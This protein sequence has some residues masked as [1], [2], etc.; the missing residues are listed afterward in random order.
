MSECRLC[1]RECGVDR[2]KEV[3]FCGVSDRVRI[4]RAAP[5]YFEE[6]CISGTRGSGAIFFAG[7]SLSCVFCQNFDV[8][9]RAKGR[10]VSVSRLAEIIDSLQGCHNINFVTG[11][12]Y[13][14]QIISALSQSKNKLPVVWNSS[15]YEKAET[16]E[17]LNG[18]ANIYLPDFK[19]RDEN[20]AK[21]FS[22]APDYFERAKNA[23][24]EMVSQRGK[25]VFDDNGMLQSGVL[26][27][28]LVLPSHTDDSKRVLSYLHA[29]YGDDIYISIMRQY[30]P[31]RDT[32]YKELSRRLTSYE[33]DKVVD[34]ALSIGVKNAFIQDKDSVGAEYTPDF[35]FTGV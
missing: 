2:E 8:S 35:D 13:T 16:L 9:H 18:K 15:G 4:A 6:P 32:P 10:E 28:H 14:P 21:C 25:C 20:A 23:L 3:G 30:T 29:E 19:Y 31:M 27:R 17:A 7:C 26:V 12:H 24:R 11:T 22:N 34:H 1:P 33:Y 5:H